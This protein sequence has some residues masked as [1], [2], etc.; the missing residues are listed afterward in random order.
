M[1]GNQ[2]GLCPKNQEFIIVIAPRM[3]SWKFRS[4]DALG[5]K[6][7]A[8]ATNSSLNQ[9]AGVLNRFH[10]WSLWHLGKYV[11]PVTEECF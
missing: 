4:W 10:A 5:S 2:G 8:R 11:G 1:L 3:F 9:K 7:T 6:L